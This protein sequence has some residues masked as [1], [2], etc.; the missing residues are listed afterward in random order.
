MKRANKNLKHIDCGLFKMES[1]EIISLTAYWRGYGFQLEISNTDGEQ[2]ED[3]ELPIIFKKFL[4]T[5]DME[6]AYNYIRKVART[7]FNAIEI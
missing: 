2:S 4:K 6:Y 1:N 7:N 3:G 5:D